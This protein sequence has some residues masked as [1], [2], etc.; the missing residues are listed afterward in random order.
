MN[1]GKDRGQSA[2][3]SALAGGCHT[4][5]SLGL[6]P[7]EMQG[8]CSWSPVASCICVHMPGV[9]TGDSDWLRMLQ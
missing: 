4:E 3:F 1:L 5:S 2:G 9:A 8:N 6:G 7:W